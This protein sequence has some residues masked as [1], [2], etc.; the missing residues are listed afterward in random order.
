ML[1]GIVCI[2]VVA[3][4]GFYYSRY[5]YLNSEEFQ[6]EIDRKIDELHK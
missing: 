3:I 4:V 2:I 1:E 5:R 6:K